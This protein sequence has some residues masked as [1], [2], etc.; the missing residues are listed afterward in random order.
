MGQPP[1]LLLRAVLGTVSASREAVGD[2][3][4]R[5]GRLSCKRRASPGSEERCLFLFDVDMPAIGLPDNCMKVMLLSG[6]QHAARC[7]REA[8]HSV[9]CAASLQLP[10]AGLPGIKF[11]WCNHST[12][13]ASGIWTATGRHAGALM[14]RGCEPFAQTAGNFDGA[15]SCHQAQGSAWRHRQ[16]GDRQG[17]TIPSRQ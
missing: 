4:V 14:R 8:L 12:G 17:N 10:P 11:A 3:M 1:K 7:E 9:K 5:R 15:G 13:S 2:A 6:C 16:L